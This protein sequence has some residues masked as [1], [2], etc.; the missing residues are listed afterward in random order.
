MAK[1]K[2]KTEFDSV[3]LLK[4]ILFFILGSIWLHSRGAQ[5]VPGVDSLPVGLL[6]GL[7][8]ARH[9]HFLIDRKIE[10]AILLG[11]ALLSYISPIGVVV[12]F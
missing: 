5:F 2:T 7:V 11:A 8:F 9:D 12:R 4:I 6:L 3:Y 1:A 10:Y